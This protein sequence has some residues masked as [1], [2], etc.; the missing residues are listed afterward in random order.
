MVCKA[1]CQ[2]SLVKAL[3]PASFGSNQWLEQIRAQVD[4]APMEALLQPMR[5]A[6]TGRPA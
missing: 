4:W 3:L 6:P 2:V 5:R 1:V